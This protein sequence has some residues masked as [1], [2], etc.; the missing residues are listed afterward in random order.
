LVDLYHKSLKEVEKAK[1]LYGAHF[2]ATSDK[3][4]TSGKRPNEA[5]KPSLTVE[6]YIDRENMIIE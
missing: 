3:A 2:N 5:T 6:D 1:G 4:I